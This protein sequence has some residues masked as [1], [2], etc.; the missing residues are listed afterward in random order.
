MRCGK[1]KK[2][3][4]CGRVKNIVITPSMTGLQRGNLH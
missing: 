1:T 4:A 3:T 2:A